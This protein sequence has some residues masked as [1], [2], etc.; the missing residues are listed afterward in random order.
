M[1]GSFISMA[2][3]D[4][5]VQTCTVIYNPHVSSARRQIDDARSAL[6]DGCDRNAIHYLIE[7]MDSIQ[8]AVAE[9]QG[10]DENGN[11]YIH[12]TGPA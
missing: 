4:D 5:N 3:S 6:D 2:E 8:R 12:N 9:A 10:C 7:A 11:Q 1:R